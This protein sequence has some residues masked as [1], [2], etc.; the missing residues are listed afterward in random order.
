MREALRHTVYAALVVLAL[1]L[2]LLSCSSLGRRL[3]W[4]F[5]APFANIWRS[6]GEL[7]GDLVPIGSSRK[8]DLLKMEARLLELEARLAQVSELEKANAELR[9]LQQLPKFPAW[10]AVVADVISRDPAQWN[11]GFG[12]NKGLVDGIRVGDAVLSGTNMIGRIVES[13]RHSAMVATV[14]S[15]ECRFSV[16]LQGSETVGVCTGTNA[17][18]WQGKA[19]FQVDFLPADLQ[20]QAGEKVLTSGLGAAMPGA[21]LVGEVLEDETGKTLQVIENSRGRLFCRAA[22]NLRTVRHVLVLCPDFVEN[23]K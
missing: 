11:K 1:A 23:P 19:H 17:G 16:T 12:I 4:S 5:F 14:L 7:A 10:Q 2:L 21:L 13:N 20:V 18:D 8:R 22:E 6:G 15:P 9:R 3:A